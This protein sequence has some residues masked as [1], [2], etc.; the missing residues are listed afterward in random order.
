MAIE[1]NR[2]CGI[3]PPAEKD[4]KKLER[5]VSIKELL[6]HVKENV[7][8]GKLLKGRLCGF[9]TLRFSAPGGSYRIVL[10][11]D[12]EWFLI[13]A[14]RKRENVYGVARNRASSARRK[15]KVLED[16]GVKVA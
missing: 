1:R 14:V 9:R 3:I 12:K 10:L 11:T 6:Q 2:T 7:H 8:R 5:G 13:V 16:L 4:L 15:L